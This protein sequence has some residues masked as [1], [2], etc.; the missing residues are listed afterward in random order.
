MEEDDKNDKM[1]RNTVDSID[2][3]QNSTFCTK[4]NVIIIIVVS[5]FI[6]AIIIGIVLFFFVFDD[7][8]EDSD[9]NGDVLHGLLE[10]QFPEI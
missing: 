2:T 3:N 1:L 10:R 7:N 5:I 6:V 9:I 8:D 4:K